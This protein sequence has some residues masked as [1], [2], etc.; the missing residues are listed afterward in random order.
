M[1]KPARVRLALAV[2]KDD[3]RHG[4]YLREGFQRDRRLPNES[5]PEM[6]GINSGAVA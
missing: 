6:Y 4:L 3:I 1:P 2:H 5:S